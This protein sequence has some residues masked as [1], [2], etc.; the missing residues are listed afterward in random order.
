MENPVNNT[1]P[2]HLDLTRM[3]F[4][5][6]AIVSIMHRVSGVLLFLLLPFVLYLLRTSLHSQSDFDQ[7][8]SMMMSSATALFFLWVLVCAVSFHFLAGLRHMLM[9][10]GLAES[11]KSARAT[12][13]LL[14]VL[15]LLV[16]IC[17]GV[18]LW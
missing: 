1:R 7:L 14:I 8:Q 4:P 3:K 2:V 10:C 12:A 9:D 11:L 18:W 6:M 17:A 15:E 5:P 16:M 13:Y